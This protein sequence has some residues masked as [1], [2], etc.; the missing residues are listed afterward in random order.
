MHHQCL[1]TA[2]FIAQAQDGLMDHITQA[3]MGPS[4]VDCFN[5]TKT[6]RKN[7]EPQTKF[8]NNKDATTPN[9]IP[10]VML[11]QCV[12]SVTNKD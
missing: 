9:G 5:F 10:F 2:L 12:L 1:E 6:S 3:A 4:N 11:L 8:S 7:D